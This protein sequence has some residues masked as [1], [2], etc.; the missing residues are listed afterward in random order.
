MDVMAII[1]WFGA[2]FSQV[3]LGVL[4]ILGGF[5]ILAKLTPTQADDKIIDAILKVIQT[6]GLAKK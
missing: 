5:S 4:S 3:I 2:N 6:I 1:T